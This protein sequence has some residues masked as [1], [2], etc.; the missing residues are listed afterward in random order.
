VLSAL[1]A[2]YDLPVLV[3]QHITDGFA[4]GLAEWLA[5]VVAVPVRMARDG[6]TP[7]PG[8]VIAPTGAHLVLQDDGRLAQDHRATPGPH[9]PSGDELLGSLARCAGSRALGVVLTGM[10]RDGARGVAEIVAAGGDAWTQRPAE[11]AVWGMPA[12]AVQAGADPRSL[13]A[14]GAGLAGL[15]RK[16]SRA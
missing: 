12:A 11:A 1:P 7:S 2:R 16:G 3:V 4:E 10:G 14:I 5:G 6:E 13:A 15:T 8:V 9:R